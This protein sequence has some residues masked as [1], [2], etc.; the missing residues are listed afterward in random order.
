MSPE[1]LADLHRRAMA[2]ARPWPPAAFS[3]LLAQPAVF[4][5]TAPGSS[6]FK[7]PGE[8]ERQGLSHRA[9]P[10]PAGFALGRAVAGEAELLT[11]A[12]GPEARWQGLGRALLGEFEAEARSRGAGAAFLEVAEDNAPALALYLVAGWSEAGRRPAY[13]ARDHG[14]PANA[15]ILRKSLTGA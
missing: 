5:V 12:V 10:D 3:D 11:L 9:A 2:H 7:Y 4:L 1:A 14:E 13:Y 15:L 6:A 8:R